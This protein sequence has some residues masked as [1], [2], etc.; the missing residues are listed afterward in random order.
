MR[1][2]A[3]QSEQRVPQ[4]SMQK[5][6]RYIA[7]NVIGA[8]MVV[9]LVFVS[10]D[11][12]AAIVDQIGS[13]VN[14][15]DMTEALIYVAITLPNRIY[16]FIP[17]SALV[18]CLL[19]LGMLAS[20]SELVVMRAAGVSVLSISWAVI[21]PVL[22][23]VFLGIVLGEYVTPLT[24][25]LSTSRKD[26]ARG[27][28]SALQTQQGLWNR[29]GNE[30]MHFNAVL[31]N[32]RL[33]GITRYH[34]NDDKELVSSSFAETAIYQGDHWQEENVAET[35]FEA[36]GTS[37]RKFPI[38]RWDNDLS[39]RVLN[40]LVLDPSA[41]SIQNLWSYTRYLDSQGLDSREYELSFWQKVLQP[42]GTLSLVLIAVSFVFGPL[43][44]VTMG[45][46]IFSGVIFGVIFRTL[47]DLL[48]PASLVFGFSPLVAVLL[49]IAICTLVGATLLARN[50]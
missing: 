1:M 21:K 8:V 26:I 7:R 5:I 42:L 32:G 39:P 23:V 2:T 22:L 16:E 19:G 40:V 49:P 4:V 25:Q 20:S 46:R 27:V 44:Q 12:I 50:R 14:D 10:L 6:N 45:F 29:E 41:L 31:P 18:G 28:P 30:F 48:G 35:L 34:F 15:Y 36:N 9:L 3:E 13:L 33:Y 43:R 17:F 38:R 24:E 11:A 37:Q 47:Q